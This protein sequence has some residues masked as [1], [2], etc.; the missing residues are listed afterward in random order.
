MS[1]VIPARRA[2][3]A[4]AQRLP[5]APAIRTTWTL[6]QVIKDLADP[7]FLIIDRAEAVSVFGPR[8]RDAGNR[9]PVDQ[10][11]GRLSVLNQQPTGGTNGVDLAIDAHEPLSRGSELCQ[12]HLAVLPINQ[13]GSLA[14]QSD[15]AT[16]TGTPGPHR[17]AAGSSHPH[18]CPFDRTG[19]FIVVPDKGLDKVFVYRLDTTRG[20]L[21][22]AD[23]P[24]SPRAPAP[25]RVMSIFI[26]VSRM[27]M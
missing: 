26:L 25:R 6:I 3:T 1:A 23:P 4:R 24:T 19:R 11:T 9:V 20:K 15:L 13:D 12:R 21:V 22:P 8:G 17:V 14:P 7:S 5:P 18:H 2:V 16:T 10:A 27:R